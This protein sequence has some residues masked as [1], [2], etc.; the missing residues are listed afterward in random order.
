MNASPKKRAPSGRYASGITPSV[1]RVNTWSTATSATATPAAN[2]ACNPSARARPRRPRPPHSTGTRSA[3]AKI[4]RILAA[5]AT[6]G[7][8]DGLFATTWFAAVLRIA[9]PGQVWQG[10]AG[11]LLGREARQG[12]ATTVAIG[13]VMHF[14]VAYGWTIAYAVLR[15]A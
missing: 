15:R 7:V 8:L 5:G 4:A 13:L 1:A 14:G 9:S 11:A 6:V 2:A 12:G 3:S 10:V